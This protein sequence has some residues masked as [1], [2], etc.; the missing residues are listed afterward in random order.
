LTHKLIKNPSFPS[1]ATLFSFAFNDIGRSCIDVK[2]PY[3]SHSIIRNPS[4]PSASFL[5][6]FSISIGGV[7]SVDAKK[8]YPSYNIVS[9]PSKP[10]PSVNQ[11]STSVDVRK[12]P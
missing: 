6:V 5:N 1:I 8:P 3:I 10:T 4:K 9:R 2:K 11:F 12:K 7:R